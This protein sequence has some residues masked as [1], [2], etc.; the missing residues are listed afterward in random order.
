MKDV[1]KKLIQKNS[2][3]VQGFRYVFD[4]DNIASH[5]MLAELE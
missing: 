2:K 4:I 1:V 5:S 3:K